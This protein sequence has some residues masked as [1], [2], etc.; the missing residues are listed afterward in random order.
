MDPLYLTI[1]ADPTGCPY[2]G[3]LLQ[4]R[5]EG[6][7]HWSVS[8]IG[9]RRRATITVELD[10]LARPVIGPHALKQEPRQPMTYVETHDG[11]KVSLS[12]KKNLVI[13]RVPNSA[14]S[15][16]WSSAEFSQRELQARLG[17]DH[18]VVIMAETA[19]L[20]V[21]SLTSEC[22]VSD[23]QVKLRKKAADWDF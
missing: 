5:L 16:D 19:K 9:G 20:D 6:V 4:R 8:T 22:T 17:E 18:V 1:Y 23:E 3:D 13:L 7:S 2:I 10:E 21:I 15:L 11:E 14:S 12:G